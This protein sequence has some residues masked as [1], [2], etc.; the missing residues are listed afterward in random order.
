MDQTGDAD[1]PADGDSSAHHHF[2]A[3]HLRTACFLVADGV[4]PSN[5]GRGYMLHRILRQA[6]RHCSPIGGEGAA[7]V[8]AGGS[9]VRPDGGRLFS[10]GQITRESPED[11]LRGEE[12]RFRS[13]LDRVLG[14]LET[15]TTMLGDGQPLSSNT[16][17]PKFQPTSSPCP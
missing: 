7:G 14:L 4:L 13:I 9:T 10:A 8:A 17:G 15:E 1:A 5:T 11:T 12:K 6:M 3:G 2:I 16:S